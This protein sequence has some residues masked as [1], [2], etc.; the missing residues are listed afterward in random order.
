MSTPAPAE[1]DV[2]GTVRFEAGSVELGLLQRTRLD[3]IREY[4]DAVPESRMVIEGH[5]GPDEPAADAATLAGR[6]AQAVADHYARSG[7]APERMELIAWTEPRPEGM[8]A[9]AAGPRVEIRRV[10]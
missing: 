1:Q 8:G 2:G 10:Q 9:T 7:I 3:A 4:F 6:R 5:V